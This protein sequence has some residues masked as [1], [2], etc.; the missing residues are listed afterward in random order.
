MTP[1]KE[2][3][4]DPTWWDDFAREGATHY[5]TECDMFCNENGYWTLSGYWVPDNKQHNWGTIRYVERPSRWTG[6]GLPPVG[7]V[8]EACYTSPD[9]YYQAK[10]LAHDEGKAV[11]RWLDGPCAGDISESDNRILCKISGPHP[12]FRPIRTPEQI[13]EE[14]RRNAIDDIANMMGRGT[15]D[16]DAARIYDAGYRK[17]DQELVSALRSL[18]EAYRDVTGIDGAYEQEIRLAEGVLKR[19]E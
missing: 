8:C 17:T 13:A 19:Y 7:A 9:E 11:Y 1:T 18:T 10:V 14:E 6:K 2:Q 15:Y 12:K 5:D 3:L 16:E 4:A